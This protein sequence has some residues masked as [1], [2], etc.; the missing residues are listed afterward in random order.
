M[1]AFSDNKQK[2]IELVHQE[3]AH[4]EL[5]AKGNTL[6]SLPA[7]E[8]NIQ[9]IDET[10]ATRLVPIPRQVR[11]LDR[12]TRARAVLLILSRAPAPSQL[13]TSRPA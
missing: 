7:I 6:V 4:Y 9:L 3:H 12:A 5:P 8:G 11:R 10:G 1:D 13:F 2:D